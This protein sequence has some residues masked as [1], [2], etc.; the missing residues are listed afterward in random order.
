LKPKNG[1]ES[2]SEISNNNWVRL[3]NSA[4][5]KDVIVKSTIFLHRNIY[6]FISTSHD[7]K[8]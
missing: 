3:V 8:T 7:S 2:S 4:A 1:N 5:S 6:K